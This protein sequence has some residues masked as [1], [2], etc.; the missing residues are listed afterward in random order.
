MTFSFR[1][2]GLKTFNMGL[3]FSLDGKMELITCLLFYPVIKMEILSFC[4][5]PY[6][7]W[8][9]AVK[10]FKKFKMLQKE[11]TNRIKH[12]YIDF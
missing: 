7:T 9:T 4:E 6:Q 8:L 12:Y 11:Y 10:I 1:L 3:V 5:K 2:F